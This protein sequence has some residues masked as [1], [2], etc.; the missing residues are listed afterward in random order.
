M[1]DKDDRELFATFAALMAVGIFQTKY[2][3]EHDEYQETNP[4]L[5][6]TIISHLTRLRVWGYFAYLAF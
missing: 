6:F 5:Q 1:C 4:I 2:I 3:S